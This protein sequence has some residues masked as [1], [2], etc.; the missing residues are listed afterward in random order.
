MKKVLFICSNM[1]IGGVQKSLLSVLK[2]FNYEDYKVDLLLFVNG[3]VLANEIPDKVNILSPIVPIEFLASFRESITLLIKRRHFIFAGVRFLS[4]V[5]NLLN[6]GFASWIISR[7]I[8]SVNNE[9]D[10]AID[11]NGQYCLYYMVDKI[12]APKKISF[13]HNDYQMWPY[14]K[15]VDKYY[16]K[17]VHMVVS[18]SEKCVMS[19]INTFPF[20][21]GKVFCIENIIS[22]KTIES[23]S[24][25]GKTFE[26]K[27][28]GI[29]IL[30]IGRIC[31]DKGVDL[32]V[33]ACKILL[34]RNINLRWYSIGPVTDQKLYKKLLNDTVVGKDFIFLGAQNNPYSFMKDA[35]IIVHP[36]RFEGK[37]IALEE[38]KVLGKPIV[39]TNYS[40]V[41]NQIIDGKTGVVV[42]ISAIA[43]A[44]GI[45]RIIKDKD[46]ERKLRAQ[47][48]I[49]FNGN[50]NEIFKLYHLLT[51]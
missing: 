14:Y 41:Q 1:E 16:Y 28:N 17:K 51:I 38:A 48:E 6:K 13:F 20:L 9:Y 36:S 21:R 26:D 33:E 2:C 43:V 18:V 4:G 37:A 27:F 29:R 46:F 5:L 25:C 44:N 42:D 34:D 10:I 40:T 11:Y 3:G 35:D 15:S 31:N 30:T 32:A 45:E 23:M 50:E 7:A 12:K 24:R 19:L 49:S 8:P 39:T 22:K 47:L